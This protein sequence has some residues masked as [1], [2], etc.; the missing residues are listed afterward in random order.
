MATGKKTD[1]EK[2]DLGKL[3]EKVTNQ[4][5]LLTYA[6][7]AGSALVKPEDRGRIKGRAVAAMYEQTD[8]ELGQIYEQIQ[9]LARQARDIQQRVE[10]SERIYK[11]RVSFE[12]I[13]GKVYHLYA[14]DD[15]DVLSMIGPE[16]WGRSKP[17]TSYIARVKLLSDHTWEIL[18]DADRP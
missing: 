10:V 7:H 17:F 6:H 11:A 9:L 13:I 5:G 15:E 4:P 2:I 12:P 3:G 1:V 14:K 8:R 18:D 16:E